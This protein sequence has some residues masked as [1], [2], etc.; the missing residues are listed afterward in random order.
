MC[1]PL[2][3]DHYPLTLYPCDNTVIPDPPAPISRMIAGQAATQRARIF[4][5]GDPFI[6]Q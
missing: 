1:H 5:R 6:A 3:D 2:D 4:Q